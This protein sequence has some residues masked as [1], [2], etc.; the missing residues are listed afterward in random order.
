M[1]GLKEIRDRQM[2]TQEQLAAASGVA[3][4]T[5]SRIETGKAKPTYRTIKSL[6]RGLGLPANEVRQAIMSDQPALL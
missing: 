2:L 4:A 6:A 3:V 5:I 1:D